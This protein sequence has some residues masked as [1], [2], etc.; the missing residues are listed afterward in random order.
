MKGLGC[1]VLFAVS[2]WF[3][4]TVT[5]GK[6]EG[7]APKSMKAASNWHV[8]EAQYRLKIVTDGPQFR[9][10]IP[11][12][13]MILPKA[14]YNGVDLRDQDGQKLPFYL[15][16]QT[17]ELIISP[18]KDNETRYVYFGFPTKQDF[19]HWDNSENGEVPHKERIRFKAISTSGRKLGKESRLEKMRTIRNSILSPLEHNM[20]R[21]KQ[22]II[23]LMKQSVLLE[24]EG[25]QMREDENL[26][27]KE[28]KEKTENYK[29]LIKQT[30][31]KRRL[32]LQ[33][34][35]SSKG[36][37]AN[38]RK[39]I[40]RNN[41]RIEVLQNELVRLD[42]EM[43]RCRYA[44]SLCHREED[45]CD[46]ALG[47]IDLPEELGIAPVL[48]VKPRYMSIYQKQ[49]SPG[50]R[51]LLTAITDATELT[52]R[53]ATLKQKE[54]TF[55]LT[56]NQRRHEKTGAEKE[57]SACRETLKGIDTQLSVA[58]ATDNRLKSKQADI[59][60]KI[61]YFRRILDQTTES[62]TNYKNR[63]AIQDQRIEKCIAEL[64]EAEKKLKELQ[65]EYE[66]ESKKFARREKKEMKKRERYIE[67]LFTNPSNGVLGEM[68]IRKIFLRDSPFTRENN[69]AG[70]FSGNILIPEDGSYTFAI[71]SASGS[72]LLLEDKVF[73]SW[74]DEHDRSKEWTRTRQAEL[75]RGLYKLDYYYQKNNGDIYAA[76]AWRPPGKAE[77]EVLRNE[78]F[79]PG[80]P[81]K[82]VTVEE[83]DGRT[84][85]AV[86]V[87]SRYLMYLDREN[88]IY[89]D[90]CVIHDPE[91]DKN[92]QAAQ[93][94]SG[95][96][97]IVEGKVGDIIY[98]EQEKDELD[99]SV[100]E[101]GREPLKLE[102]ASSAGKS[103]ICRPDLFL[104]LWSPT[105]I[106]DDEQLELHVEI[107]SELPE[108]VYCELKTTV[109]KANAML[110]NNTERI[111]LRRK[112]DDDLDKYTP[113]DYAKRKFTL[114]GDLLKDGLEASFELSVFGHLF[115]SRKLVFRPL[116]EIGS[117]KLSQGDL[118]NED[119]DR[120]V[121][122]LHRPALS[123][124]RN[125]QLSKLVLNKVLL[126]GTVLVVGNDFSSSD[127]S[128]RK[129]LA[130]VL[131]SDDMKLE[132]LSWQERSN[133]APCLDSF[134]RFSDDV[135]KSKAETVIIIPSVADVE[136]GVPTRLQ[137]RVLAALIQM[138]K[139]NDSI[140][141]VK[142]CTP[143][144]SILYSKS[145][146]ELNTAVK[147]LAREYG[148]EMI[149]L[150]NA[151]SSQKD[152]Q[153]L[154]RYQADFPGLEEAYPVQYI[155]ELCRLFLKNLP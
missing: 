42:D 84:Y 124:I 151:V 7:D 131:K 11:L 90:K 53:Y 137:K 64:A 152:W 13:Q 9:G 149:D 63:Y 54:K 142:I 47:R 132:F 70:H 89:W 51:R 65:Q 37:I 123:E 136:A 127:R 34:D 39:Q 60:H 1:R 3:A 12:G 26:N 16:P 23:R 113:A 121:P 97:V 55:I 143:Y 2:L 116:R 133:S 82:P 17:Y 41:K 43:K 145:A 58:D 104:H 69:F 79:A 125:W 36:D 87:E 33:E 92:A 81:N 68:A 117:L 135:G 77:F 59:D 106:Y 91:M 71:N 35:N 107:M 6:K 21:T 57:I 153:K 22:N 122:V 140:R 19:N 139:K 40:K 38:L 62:L 86:T 29:S 24:L 148:F 95:E 20:E 66:Q 46:S 80:W 103:V 56:L 5:G 32:L 8:P 44:I 94:L 88:K 115:A 118:K 83:K 146:E 74:L 14:L 111:F 76:A 72:Y 93:W 130:Q 27:K 109:N 75:K 144:P 67:S 30:N 73:L 48:T 98:S 85:P 78:D 150:Y 105:F 129:S 49:V 61:D 45:S 147:S 119:N 141:S 28:L 50:F 52:R 138:L 112:G 4:T 15:Y 102:F 154:Y 101:A 134:A 25:Y 10:F 128:F 99:L 114:K 126:P 120:I 96:K 18:S 110:K 155:P 31:E 100:K 108:P